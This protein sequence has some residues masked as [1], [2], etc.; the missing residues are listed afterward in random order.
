MKLPEWVRFSKNAPNKPVARESLIVVF[1]SVRVQVRSVWFSNTFDTRLLVNRGVGLLN[2]LPYQ[3]PL[4]N[5]MS[6]KKYS[7][8]PIDCLMLFCRQVRSRS[9]EH[10]Q[11]VKLLFPAKVSSQIISILRQELD[12]MIRVAHR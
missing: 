5:R 8:E 4:D 7:S 9:D 6:I 2:P 1:S 11:A 12:S 10:S 3:Q